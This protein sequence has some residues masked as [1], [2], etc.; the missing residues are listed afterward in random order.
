MRSDVIYL[1]HYILYG[2]GVYLSIYVIYTLVLILSNYFLREK[3]HVN[4]EQIT[5]FAVI[6]PAH[7]EELLLDRLLSSISQLTYPRDLV[8][9]FVVADNCS[10][11]TAAIGR[12]NGAVVLERYDTNLRGKGYAIK[13]AL[14]NINLN[15]CDAIFVV[16]ADSIVEA[17]SMNELDRAIQN[18]ARIMQCYNGLANPDESWFTRIMDV[19]RTLGNEVLEPAKEKIGLASHLMGNGMC[20]V[21]DVIAMYGWDAFTVGEDWEYY[22]K[23]VM[24]GERIAFVNK[25]RVYHSESVNLKQ[26]TSQRLRWSSGRFAIAAKYGFRLLYNGVKS[27]SI[28]TIDAAMPL[29]L[30]NPSLGISL[31]IMMLIACLVVPPPAYRNILIGWSS[32][33]ILLQLAFFLV[34]IL[35]VKDKK[36]KLLAILF[37][38][39]FLIWKSGLD[40]LSAAGIGR[41]SWVRTDRKL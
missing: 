32:L 19:S 38:P 31:T 1:F 18:G 4:R 41:K 12:N 13:Y 8:K 25:A 37:A 15:D 35:Y 30:P 27:R 11:A 3:D 22:A 2:L 14:A 34:G 26:A 33:L 23:L 10:D 5:H 21:R 29:L 24:R 9:L 17:S 20:F 39:I 40:L 28:K 16:D 6:I 36:M 7:N